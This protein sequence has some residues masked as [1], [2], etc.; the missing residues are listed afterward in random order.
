MKILVVHVAWRC[1]EVV[2][3]TDEKQA[4]FS[5][6]NIIIKSNYSTTKCLVGSWHKY[7]SIG[8]KLKI[9]LFQITQ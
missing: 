1:S 9:R 8:I 5:S 7:E 3:Q 6:K 2:A 4:M